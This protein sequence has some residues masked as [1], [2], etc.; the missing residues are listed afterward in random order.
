M[1]EAERRIGDKIEYAKDQYDALV[2]ADCLMLVTEWPQFRVP[3][4]NVVKKLLKN[5]VIFDGRNIYDKH[6]LKKLGFDYYGI[7]IIGL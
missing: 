3:T 7:G 5:H 2:D 6:E 1:E 4:Y